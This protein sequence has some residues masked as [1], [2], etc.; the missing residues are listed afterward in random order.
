MREPI[1]HCSCKPILALVVLALIDQFSNNRGTWSSSHLCSNCTTQLPC[2][3]KHSTSYLNSATFPSRISRTVQLMHYPGPLIE[4]QYSPKI[5]ISSIHQSKYREP[6]V[7]TCDRIA[8]EQL[9]MSLLCI[10]Y[11]SKPTAW[12]KDLQSLWPER[13]YQATIYWK[14][15]APASEAVFVLVVEIKK[16]RRCH[17]SSNHTPSNIPYWGVS[18]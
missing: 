15:I 3:S 13:F 18:H 7:W 16:S 12:S 8:H 2:S 10:A 6:F 5:N 11:Q 9:L 17:F 1:M 4:F 14:F